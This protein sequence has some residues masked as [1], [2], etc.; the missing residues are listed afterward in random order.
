MESARNDLERLFGPLA[1][2]IPNRVI[3]DDTGS[4]VL[5]AENL[6]ETPASICCDQ[7]WMR[8][9]G[10][11]FYNSVPVDGIDLCIDKRSSR[12][13]GLLLLSVVFHPEPVKVDI[14]LSHPASWISHFRVWHETPR[15]H[16]Y[17]EGYETLPGFFGY[18]PSEVGR[19][20]WLQSLP[21]DPYQLP[22]LEITTQDE[23]GPING[24]T[25]DFWADFEARDTV[26]IQSSDQ[27]TVRL[28]ELLLNASLEDNDQDEFQL[29]QE[30][31]FRGVGPLSAEL[32]IWLPGS[33]GYDP[34]D[35]R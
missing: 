4:F 35:R 2:T 20:P 12:T 23:M 27:G 19:H 26:V 10:L 15:P 16:E 3:D 21:P 22:R 8:L 9:A 11:H 31:G 1:D 28:A 30:G 24:V 34:N 14:E 29:E 6:P 32:R 17:S 33:L 13:L 7:I 5:S 25:N 18:R